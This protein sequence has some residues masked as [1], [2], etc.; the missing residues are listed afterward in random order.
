MRIEN[1]A[2]LIVLAT[3]V[4]ISG[5]TSPSLKSPKE[6]AQEQ[7]RESFDQCNYQCGEGILNSLCKEKCT[8]DYNNRLDEIEKQYPN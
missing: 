4:L 1:I 5:C 7:A 8:Y 6:Q 3:I 2:I